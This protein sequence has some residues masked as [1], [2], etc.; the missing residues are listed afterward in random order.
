MIH[1]FF[2]SQKGL[3]AQRVKANFS[4]IE[5]RAQQADKEKEEYAKNQA[6]QEAR[7][8]EEQEKQM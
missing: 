8:Q 6:I 4:E 7:T 2:F 1:L 5:N 3:G